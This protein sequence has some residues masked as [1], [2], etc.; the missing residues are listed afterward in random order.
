LDSLCANDE[1]V[2]LAQQLVDGSE[3]NDKEL[4]QSLH[5]QIVNLIT[6][7]SPNENRVEPKCCVII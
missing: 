6:P 7:I 3:N 1:I 2:K 5:E 4:R